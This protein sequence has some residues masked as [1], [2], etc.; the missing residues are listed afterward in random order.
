[1]VKRPFFG[2]EILVAAE[3]RAIEKI[4]LKYRHEP[5]SD[6]LKKKI[7]DSLSDAKEKGTITIPFAVVMRK[8]PSNI[9]RNIIEILL[10]T[11]L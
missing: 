1:M 9:H 10:E 8:D 4:L 11:K 3:R 7:Y 2:K 6:E 5:V